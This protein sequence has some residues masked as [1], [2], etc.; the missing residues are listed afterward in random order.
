MTNAP[1][2]WTVVGIV[3]LAVLAG[4]TIPVLYQLQRT[5]AD[6]RR[7][8]NMLNTRLTATLVEVQETGERVNRLG[9][10][11]DEHGEDIQR[12]M[13]AI[14]GIARP[15]EE[16]QVSVEKAAKIGKAVGPAIVAGYEAFVAY[17]ATRASETEESEFDHPT[18]EPNDAS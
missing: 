7:F 11:L 3:L 17:R 15:L 14:G 18:E 10:E 9:R 4:A 5:L 6:T 1:S 16:I 12:V 2:T 8:V 13:A